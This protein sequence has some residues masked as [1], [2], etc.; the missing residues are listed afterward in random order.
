MKLQAD[1]INVGALI[2]K[3]PRGLAVPDFQRNYSWQEEQLQAFWEDLIALSAD[4]QNGEH[5][6]GPIVLLNGKNGRDQIIDGQQRLTTL[7]VLLKAVEK[8]LSK[9]AQQKQAEKLDAILV[10]EKKDLIFL[11]FV[12]IVGQSEFALWIPLI[13]YFFEVGYSLYD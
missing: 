5:F 10:K 9:N 7:V 13:M 1:Q 12:S 3:T 2:T 11:L 6:F 8:N 4:P